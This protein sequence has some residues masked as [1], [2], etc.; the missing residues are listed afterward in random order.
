M[1]KQHLSIGVIGCGRIG[2]AHI[3]SVQSIT[4]CRLAALA[5]NRRPVALGE[6]LGLGAEA[7]SDD[8]RQML[9]RP[10]IDAVIVATPT[11]THLPIA[12]DAI[13]AGK[14][15]LVEKPVTMDY[16]GAAELAAAARKAG[17]TLMVGQSRR[18]P[19]AVAELVKRLPQIGPVF[20]IHIQ[21][22]VSFPAP[23]TEWWKSSRRARGL[24]VP[25]QGSHSLDSIAWWMGRAPDEIYASGARRNPAWEGEDEADIFCRF[26]GGQVATVHLSLS[27]SPPVHEA[28]VVG[29]KGVLRLVETPTGQPFGFAFRLDHD[30]Q[31]VFEEPDGFPYTR[32]VEEFVTALHEGRAPL[33]SIDQVLPA[34]RMMDAAIDSMSRGTPVKLGRE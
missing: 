6:E 13:A 33:A 20:R 12:R 18:F 31:T 16:P 32:Q 25:L 5:S 19:R 2:R 11:D 17:V 7:V 22:L 34:M 26:D 9:A 27:T 8:Y 28:I 3:K 14:H 21:F 4:G 1:S 30:G 15:L 10:D 29:E 24:V 23:P